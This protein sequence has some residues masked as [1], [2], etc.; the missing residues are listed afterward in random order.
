MRADCFL[1]FLVYCMLSLYF[2]LLPK[3]G[4]QALF[5]CAAVFKETANSIGRFL[6]ISYNSP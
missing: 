5:K 3:L 6:A 2:F 1:K 4:L